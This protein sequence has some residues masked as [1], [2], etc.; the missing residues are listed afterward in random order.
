MS[1]AGPSV[2][3]P[4]SK[5]ASALSGAAL[6]AAIPFVSNRLAKPASS[7]LSR[8]RIALATGGSLAPVGVSKDRPSPL[9]APLRIPT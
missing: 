7:P 9:N 8:K 1:L 4:P 5:S 6:L 2:S 3:L